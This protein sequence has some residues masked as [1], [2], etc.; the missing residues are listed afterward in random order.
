M[1][2][3]PVLDPIL[4]EPT[5]PVATSEVA[6][7]ARMH[8]GVEGEIRALTGER[9]ANF[10]LAGPDGRRYVVKFAHP[11][12]PYVESDL[13]SRVLLHLESR[14]PDLPLPRVRRPI[15]TDALQVRVAPSSGEPRQ[16]RVYTYLEG[17]PAHTGTSCWAFPRQLGALAGRV[18]RA[19][20]DFEH[21]ADGRCIDWDLRRL[22]MMSPAGRRPPE[23]ECAVSVYE[24]F[25]RDRLGDFA[26]QVV[27][28]DLNPH[29]ILIDSEGA[30][31]ITGILDF[32]DLIRAPRAVEVATA[33]AYHVHDPTA[34]WRDALEIVRG[35]HGVNPLQR[36]ELEVIPALVA[37]RVALSV[38]VNREQ[39]RLHSDNAEY[40]LRNVAR[41]QHALALLAGLDLED[42]GKDFAREVIDG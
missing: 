9:D 17:V 7:L 31:R 42:A 4:L 27:H 29:N 2:A 19:L 30:H 3:E 13:Q 38:T 15:T 28:N 11:R 24:T 40:L 23:I 20:E 21:E 32:G 33:A 37:M 18:D 10:L 34:P 12:E 22:P 25:A 14:A 16:L 1:D 26:D 8:F 36:E 35:Y 6:D 41:T 5:A 39:A